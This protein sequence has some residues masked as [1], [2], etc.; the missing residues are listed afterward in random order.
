MSRHQHRHQLLVTAVVTVCLLGAGASPAN[1]G[2]LPNPK[3]VTCTADQLVMLTAELHHVTSLGERRSIH[4][5]IVL[6][7]VDGLLEQS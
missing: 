7:Y 6:T 3:R 1:A 4:D 5:E 2:A